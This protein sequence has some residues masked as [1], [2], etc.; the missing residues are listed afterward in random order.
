MVPGQHRLHPRHAE[1]HRAGRVGLPAELPGVGPLRPAYSLPL[2]GAGGPEEVDLQQ[3]QTLRLC[4]L[5][6]LLLR[7]AGSKYL[8][9]RSLKS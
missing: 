4:R 7:E 3:S 1:V 8:Q 6:S 5:V 9:K 2:N